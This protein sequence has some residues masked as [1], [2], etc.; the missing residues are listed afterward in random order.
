MDDMASGTMRLLYVDDEPRLL[1]LC[2]H[3]LERNGNFAVE[4]A[5]GLE[6]ATAKAL[7][8]DYDAIVSDYNL[9]GADGLE[10]LRNVRAAGLRTPFIVFTGR[11]DEE[12]AIRAL[13]LG[14]DSY[15]R[16]DKD[17][18]LLYQELEEVLAREAGRYRAERLRSV[19]LDL[20][21]LLSAG[22]GLQA[23]LDSMV[24]IAER[25]DPSVVC[26]VMLYDEEG[27]VLRPASGRGLGRDYWALLSEGVPIGER[28]GSCGTAAHT[29]SLASAPD[30][31]DSPLWEPFPQVVATLLASGLRSCWSKP[32]LSSDGR[33][34]GTVANYGRDTGLPTDANLSVL[35]W[36]VK[37]AA[38]VIERSS[39]EGWFATAYDRY[40]DML[41]I[42]DEAIVLLDGEGGAVY[43]NPSAV[44]LLED[45]AVEGDGLAQML[46]EQHR[47][48]LLLIVDALRKGD[49]ADMEV[50]FRLPTGRAMPCKVH[51]RGDCIDGAEWKVNMVIEELAPRGQTVDEAWSGFGGFASMEGALGRISRLFSSDEGF[52]ESVDK[53]LAVLGKLSGADRTYLFLRS[54]D[55]EVMRNTHEW[56]AEGVESMMHLLQNE[57][58]DE[59]VWWMERLEQDGVIEIPDVSSM[60]PEAGREKSTLDMQGIKSLYVLPLE[61]NG[62]LQ[63]F[64]GFDDVESIG[65]WSV[66]DKRLLRIGADII[67]STVALE[68]A[69]TELRGLVREGGGRQ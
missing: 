65:D 49:K 12:V 46:E 33:L 41:S 1:D 51:L 4:T 36:L 15:I 42:N 17:A 44:S 31:R 25:H 18:G 22:E 55:G 69:E 8:N 40:K 28:H 29:L 56:C 14:A 53:A 24:A 60:P 35:D 63:G 20:L 23:V 27:G 6:E 5:S 61:V 38:I 34:L 13:N 43:A 64:I 26:T 67:A 39:L 47:G 16:K 10:L 30:I 37:V 11:G 45:A 57:R 2:R 3:H 9:G 7:G 68:K 32:I 59:I 19:E 62:E 48:R 66:E 58:V 52:D 50:I 21:K 54:D